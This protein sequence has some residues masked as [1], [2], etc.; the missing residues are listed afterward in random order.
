MLDLLLDPIQRRYLVEHPVIAWS[1][2]I[3]GREEAQDI[4]TI[5]HSDHHDL[6]RRRS[7]RSVSVLELE[8]LKSFFFEKLRA[9]GNIVKRIG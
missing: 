8:I 2:R 6:R 1:L 4:E 9:R 3:H 7:I 5:R